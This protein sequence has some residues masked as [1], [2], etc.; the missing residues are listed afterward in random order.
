LLTAIFWA[1]VP[2]NLVVY[3]HFRCACC[4]HHQSDKINCPD[5]GKSKHLWNINTPLPYDVVQWPR[6]QPNK[7][8]NHHQI[9]SKLVWSWHQSLA[10]A[11]TRELKGMT[12]LT[13]WGK[14]QIQASLHRTW[15]GTDLW[16]LG[17]SS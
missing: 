5:D 1:V 8:L 16:H 6:R 2:Y 11:R 10:Y 12:L 15:T 3:Q 14:N 9:S 17:N 7:A 4:L 13:N